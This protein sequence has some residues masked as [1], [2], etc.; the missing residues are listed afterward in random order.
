MSIFEVHRG[1]REPKA[2]LSFVN[3]RSLAMMAVSEPAACSCPLQSTAASSDELTWG[4]VVLLTVLFFHLSWALWRLV[5][6][7]RGPAVA[8]QET[9]S[10][11]LMDVDLRGLKKRIVDLENELKEERRKSATFKS[12]RSFEK[13]WYHLLGLQKSF[14]KSSDV[15]LMPHGTVW[16][17]SAACATRTTGNRAEKNKPEVRRCCQLCGPNIVSDAFARHDD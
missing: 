17:T 13:R 6:F 14:V 5:A 4:Q 12:D 11:P 1:T 15:F 7:L 2:I 9:D 8:N 16:H 10:P 3:R